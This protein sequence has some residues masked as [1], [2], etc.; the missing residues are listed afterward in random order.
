[1][2]WS[3]GR[4]SSNTFPLSHHH[5]RSPARS[6]IPRHKHRALKKKRKEKKKKKYKRDFSEG[7]GDQEG[8]RI[9]MRSLFLAPCVYIIGLWE[10]N[11]WVKRDATR[12]QGHN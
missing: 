7:L 2:G 1:M 3:L 12:G 4:P 6:S 5:N 11:S 10:A 9:E 8:G